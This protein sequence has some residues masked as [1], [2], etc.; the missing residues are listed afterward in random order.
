MIASML[1]ANIATA[2]NELSRLLRHVKRGHS[3][4]ITERN[5]PVARIEPVAADAAGVSA[6]ALA[7]LHG[8]GVLSP[9]SRPTLDVEAFLALPS[10]T[11]P[12]GLGLTAAVLAEREETR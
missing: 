1:T 9:P 6:S 11:V 3:V 4:L 5:R 7:A 10:A 8:M 12:P 2:K